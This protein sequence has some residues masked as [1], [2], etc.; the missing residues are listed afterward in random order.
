MTSS[1]GSPQD[2]V[3]LSLSGAATVYGNQHHGKADP[4]ADRRDG[5]RDPHRRAGTH[6]EDGV[7]DVWHG[8]W[9]TTSTDVSPLN[10]PG[11]LSMATRLGSRT[12]GLGGPTKRDDFAVGQRMSHR[13]NTSWPLARRP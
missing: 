11:I 6:S 4:D 2:S 7:R 12:T 5:R 8:R 13:A 3:P 1:R 9:L 10:V